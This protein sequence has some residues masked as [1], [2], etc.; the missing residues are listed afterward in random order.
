MTKIEAIT[1]QQ[2]LHNALGP[3]FL[4]GAASASYQI[5]GGFDADG[6]GQNIWDVYLRSQDNGEVACDSYHLWKED[7]KLLKAYECNTYRFSISWARIRPLGMCFLLF[8]CFPVLLVGLNLYWRQSRLMELPGGKND[9]VNEAGIK[10]YSDLIDVL[11]AED[12]TPCVTIF[13]WDH[14]QELENRYKGFSSENIV[15]DFVAYAKVLFERLGDRVKHWITI[16]EP[17]I[18]SMLHSMAIR[19]DSWVRDKDNAM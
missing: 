16:N 18:I 14:P 6:K 10:Y 15:E 17:F 1:K 12:I 8:S 2:S 4:Y 11:L 19:K 7:I 5:E 9:P 13:H 3:K